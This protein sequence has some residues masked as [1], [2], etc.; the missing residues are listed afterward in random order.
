MIGGN[1]SAGTPEK[2]FL[3]YN[4]LRSFIALGSPNWKD[5]IQR[6][7]KNI[8]SIQSSARPSFATVMP[9]CALGQIFHAH[10][11]QSRHHLVYSIS[12]NCKSM[13][14]VLD[15]G[16]GLPFKNMNV[17]Q[18]V[19]LLNRR[20][21]SLNPPIEIPFLL[22]LDWNFDY[23]RGISMEK[24]APYLYW[25]LSQMKL[26]VFLLESLRN[27]NL[28]ENLAKLWEKPNLSPFRYKS[29]ICL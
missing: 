9:W 29:C 4:M 18:L 3:T 5:Q 22:V 23:E 14:R 21:I 13:Q 2:W 17:M 25:S 28:Q 10:F 16:S 1:F 11:E 6:S 26:F 12:H 20:K 7:N 8:V 27:P 24:F 19:F 15:P